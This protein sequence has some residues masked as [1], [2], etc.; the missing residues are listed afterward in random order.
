MFHYLF[1]VLKI[2]LFSISSSYVPV[3]RMA[4]CLFQFEVSI[5]LYVLVFLKASL[6]SDCRSNCRQ[7][8]H[9]TVGEQSEP[10]RS[11]FSPMF[12]FTPVTKLWT[13]YWCFPIVGSNLNVL[14]CTQPPKLVWETCLT[15]PGI[16]LAGNRYG[17]RAQLYST[18]TFH[19]D[20]TCLVGSGVQNSTGCFFL[21]F[22]VRR[23][24]ACVACQDRSL[25]IFSSSGR[26]YV[27]TEYRLE[28]REQVLT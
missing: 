24:I 17:G 11:G 9:A 26:R 25:C 14:K 4:H 5:V 2:L 28:I 7:F 10:I 18:R 3:T 13:G 15:S 27:K 21:G 19:P 6:F 12:A 22:F 8:S 1:I 16:A 20:P 23:C